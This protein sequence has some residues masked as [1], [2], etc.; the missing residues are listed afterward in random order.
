MAKYATLMET[1]G[2]DFESWYYFI[3]WQGN[4]RMLRKLNRRLRQF[5][6]FILRDED[7]SVFDLDIMNLVSAQTAKGDDK[8]GN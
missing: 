5:D 1:S 7:V 3:K 2:T 6:T 8:I 4:E